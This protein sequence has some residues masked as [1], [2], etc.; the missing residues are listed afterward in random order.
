MNFLDFSDGFVQSDDNSR[1]YR[2]HEMYTI[3]RVR[4]YISQDESRRAY[5]L[6]NKRDDTGRGSGVQISELT[7]QRLISELT[8]T[9]L[10]RAIRREAGQF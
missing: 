5:P 9:I 2:E 4:R 8:A 3:V 6:G 1:L 7:E 10:Q